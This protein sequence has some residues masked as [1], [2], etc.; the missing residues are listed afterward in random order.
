M[1]TISDLGINGIKKGMKFR[2]PN[3]NSVT[4]YHEIASDVQLGY[5]GEYVD[6][7]TYYTDNTTSSTK[8]FDYEIA[9]TGWAGCYVLLEEN[10]DKYYWEKYQSNPEPVKDVCY[11]VNRKKVLLFNLSGYWM[12][13]KCK[14]DLGTL[15][16]EEFYQAVKEQTGG[17]TVKRAPPMG[18]PNYRRRK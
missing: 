11:H 1:T 16:E 14:E 4:D 7:T 3:P 18:K 8:W 9:V 17:K 12:C 6:I 2:N 15:T 5:C 13:E 10:E